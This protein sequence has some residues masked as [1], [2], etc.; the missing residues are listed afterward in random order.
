LGKPQHLGRMWGEKGKRRRAARLSG[1]TCHSTQPVSRP[2]RGANPRPAA[3]A[4]SVRGSSLDGGGAPGASKDLSARRSQF[5]SCDKASFP[6]QA[7]RRGTPPRPRG[8][9]H[10]TD[11]NP[12]SPV[13]RSPWQ[14]TLMPKLAHMLR[15]NRT[16][17]RTRG[18]RRPHAAR[19]NAFPAFRP[20]TPRK[21]S[22]ER[23]L[24]LNRRFQ[25]TARAP[26][27][28]EFSGACAHEPRTAIKPTRLR[29]CRPPG[30]DR[31]PQASPKNNRRIVTGASPPR[32]S[33]HPKCN[34][35]QVPPAFR[36]SARPLGPMRGVIRTTV[37]GRT[38]CGRGNP[39]RLRFNTLL[40]RNR[41]L[42]LTVC[43]A[44]LKTGPAP[45]VGPDF[46]PSR[47]DWNPIR[48]VRPA[49]SRIRSPASRDQYRGIGRNDVS[50]I[51]SVRAS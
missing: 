23:D 24:R 32:C 44:S 14:S 30:S 6:D 10:D 5:R 29:D 28:P 27:N 25:I 33:H 9:P 34:T 7:I 51:N 15:H 43:T 17:G 41:P 20:K 36:R 39:S 47:L 13:S 35:E 38:T 42:E 22:P 8:L 19:I 18:R 37:L 45:R 4:A 46:Q 48:R 49:A 40:P 21:T 1:L 31:Y 12:A 16:N 3:L 50:R 2:A 11:R 26:H